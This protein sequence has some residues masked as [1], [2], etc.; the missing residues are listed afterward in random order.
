[1]VEDVLDE[2]DIAEEDEGGYEEPEY[3]HEDADRVSCV[4]Q[5]IL[6]AAKQ[7]DQRNNKFRSH[8][9]I[10]KKVC[11]VIVDKG[12]CENLVAR[13]LVEHLKLPM[14]RHSTPYKIEWIQKGPT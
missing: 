4:V 11:D 5:R 8:C 13:R 10:N 9:I 6:C 2:E 14:E 7:P 1:M 3:A 12:S